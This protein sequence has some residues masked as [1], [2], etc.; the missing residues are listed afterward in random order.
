MLPRFEV[1]RESA[2]NAGWFFEIGNIFEFRE[3]LK[4]CLAARVRV[5][6][7][8]PRLSRQFPTCFLVQFSSFPALLWRFVDD[9]RVEMWP[10]MTWKG[11]CGMP[12]SLAA[13]LVAM[14]CSMFWILIYPKFVKYFCTRKWNGRKTRF[15]LRI[16]IFSPYTCLEK[17]ILHIEYKLLNIYTGRAMDGW[18][19]KWIN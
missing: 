2:I 11:V 5:S 17:T 18:S 16:G 10:A 19:Y 7:S 9:V 6:A 3:P 8:P 4:H 1:S 15:S 12:E 13:P 14:A